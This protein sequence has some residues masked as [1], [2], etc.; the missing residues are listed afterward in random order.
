[1]S[2]TTKKHEI[3]NATQR[4]G[5][6]AGKINEKVKYKHQLFTDDY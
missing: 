4:K 6:Q 5:G 3:K 2:K 1:M